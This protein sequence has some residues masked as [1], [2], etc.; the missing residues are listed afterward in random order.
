MTVN[1]VHIYIFTNVPIKVRGTCTL[2][3][4]EKMRRSFGQGFNKFK[5]YGII[6]SKR[7]NIPVLNLASL[8]SEA[9]LLVPDHQVSTNLKH[10][11]DGFLKCYIIN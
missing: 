11:S 2:K 9:S 7:Q 1:E 3:V 6:L 10:E 8:L 4:R 5:S